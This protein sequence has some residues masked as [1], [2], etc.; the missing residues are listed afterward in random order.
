MRAEDVTV[1]TVAVVDDHRTFAELLALA[2]D[3][4]DQFR[5]LAHAATADEARTMIRQRRPD[6]VLMDVELPD[7]DGIALTAEV[8]TLLPETRVVVLTSH[9]SLSLASRA[10]A[11]GASAFYTKDGSLADLLQVLRTLDDGPVT[12]TAPRSGRSP[13]PQDDLIPVEL[14][15]RELEVLSL[16]AQGCGVEAMA[17]RMGITRHTCRGY[18]K[19]LYLKLGVHSQLEALVAGL[20]RGLIEAPGPRPGSR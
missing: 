2:L 3:G 5:Y 12:V 18:V 17:T 11:A 14:A 19:S 16:M 9:N 20:A 4:H 13:R 10:V 6:I 8:R 1:R 7:G 15:A